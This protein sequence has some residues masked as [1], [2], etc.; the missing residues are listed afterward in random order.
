ATVFF[1]P[2]IV[3]VFLTTIVTCSSPQRS[4]WAAVPVNDF[5]ATL[6]FFFCTVFATDCWEAAHASTLGKASASTLRT[7]VTD[8]RIGFVSLDEGEAFGVDVTAGD[9]RA[10]QVLLEN[11]G[12]RRRPAE[13]DDSHTDV[14]HE[15]IEMSC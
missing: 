5:V 6:T 7:T 13:E 3:V 15:L 9:A 11:G 12:N 4:T 10:A 1:L 14:M 8:L 2:T